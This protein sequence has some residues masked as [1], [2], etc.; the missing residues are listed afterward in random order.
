MSARVDRDGQAAA[1]SLDVF[2]RR[3]DLGRA[4]EALEAA[5]YRTEL[6]HPHWLGKAFSDDLF[7]DLS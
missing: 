5:G 4:F 1:D 7:V 2:L 6:T 3:R